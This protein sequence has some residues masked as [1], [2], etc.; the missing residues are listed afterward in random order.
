M[1]LA[2]ALVLATPQQPPAPLAGVRIVIDPGHPS[3]NGNGTRGRDVTELE[4]CWKIGL[5]FKEYLRRRGAEVILTK[6]SQNER[7]TNRRRAEIANQVRAHYSIRLH[8]DAANRGGFASYYPD[9]QGRVDGITGP[10]PSVIEQSRRY[11][12]VFHPALA[13]GLSGALR[14]NGL[15]TD[16][17]TAIGGR[18]GALSGSIYSEVPVVLVEMAVLTIRSDEEWIS[19]RENQLKYAEA[20]AAAVEAVFRKYPVTVGASAGGSTVASTVSV[21]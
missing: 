16:R 21:E 8:C 5:S 13:Q 10:A 17:Q 18:Q 4:I 20:L 19:R 9:R 3:E 7:V 2:L 11:A 1:T 15:L 6:S 14:N 12:Q